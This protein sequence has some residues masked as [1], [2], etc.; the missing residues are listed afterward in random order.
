M[1][2]PPILVS[3]IKW[4][5][6]ETLAGV[7]GQEEVVKTLERRIRAR[8][9][10]NRHIA[11][12]GPWGVGKMTLVRLYSQALICDA[13][14]AEGAPCQT[15]GECRGVIS[16]SSF[17]YVE[18]DAFDWTDTDG[19]RAR[20]EN[21][22]R[23]LIKRGQVGFRT[24]RCRVV[25]FNNAERLSVSAADVALKTLEEETNTVFIFVVNDVRRFSAALRSRC[26]VFQLRP[27]QRDLLADHLAQVCNRNS[28]PYEGASLTVIAGASDGLCGIASHMVALL[29]ARGHLTLKG[30][31]A[32]LGLAW[33][34]DMLRCWQ[35]IFADQFD[36]ALLAFERVGS[37]GP[38]RV[39][40][41]QAFLLELDL[42]DELGVRGCRIS[43]ALEALPEEEWGLVRE[44]WERF[45]VSRS[46]KVGDL[47]R[48]SSDFWRG[49][50]SDAP[51]QIVFRRAYEEL[52]NRPD[53]RRVGASPIVGID[54]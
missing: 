32:D 37:D 43:P 15:C 33:G 9:D 38:S 45:A 10:L 24:A 12:V 25:V 42:R 28:I 35:A 18:I 11:F 30:A 40:A 53:E 17:A 4:C 6:P 50:R 2:A 13:P 49:A 52:A 19:E 34:F 46:M 47:I 26:L 51:W 29:A 20:D 48:R 54:S 5:G 16:G 3:S 39:R 22:V 8:R 41:M 31:R 36:E 1:N 23:D 44:N 21:G 14:D 27:V 7:V